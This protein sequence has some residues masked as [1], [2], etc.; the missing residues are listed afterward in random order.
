VTVAVVGAGPAGLHAASTAAR[1]GASVLLIDAGAAAGGQYH[2]HTLAEPPPQAVAKHWHPRIDHR[3]NTTVWAIDGRRL[4]LRTGPADSAGGRSWQVDA[5]ALVLATGAYDR[6][7]AFPGWDLPGVVTAGGAQA[8]AKTHGIA[9]G[10]RVIVTGSGP[11]LL[12]VATSLL[13]TG[14]RVV[15]VLE[16]GSTIAWRRRPRAVAQARRT[17]PTCVDAGASASAVSNATRSDSRARARPG[18]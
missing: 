9:V 17:R 14:A 3:P 13:R 18:R 12:P 5:D 4:F 6:A 1:C 7:L 2:R 16:A 11:F 15:A 8:M 10:Q